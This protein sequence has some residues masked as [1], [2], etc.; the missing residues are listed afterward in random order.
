MDAYLMHG[1]GTP[2][3]FLTESV[4]HKLAP[5]PWQD[6]GLTWT[7]T[8][9]GARIPTRHMVQHN[10]R[11]RRVYCCAY[12]NVGTCFIGR[13]LQTGTVVEID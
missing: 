11:W 10:G 13:N 9:Y 7:A 5:M 4:P 3:P 8:G 12:S 1:R 2:G 6:R